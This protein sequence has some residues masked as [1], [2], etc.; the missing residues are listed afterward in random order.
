MVTN[1]F[2][3]SPKGGTGGVAPPVPSTL[4]SKGGP[5][6]DGLGRWNMRL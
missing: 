4:S 3:V 1:D 5:T 6:P 2:A